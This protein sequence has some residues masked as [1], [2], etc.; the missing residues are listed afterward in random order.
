M[1][2]E[3]HASGQ[4]P[5]QLSGGDELLHEISNIVGKQIQKLISPV[6]CCE[7]QIGSVCYGGNPVLSGTQRFW[8]AT[9]HLTVLLGFSFAVAGYTAG[10]SPPYFNDKE[11]RQTS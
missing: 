4:T 6:D 2:Y 10:A 3:N 11:L 5:D 9:G 8:T 7:F 1:C